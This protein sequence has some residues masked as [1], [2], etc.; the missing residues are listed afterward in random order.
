VHFARETAGAARTRLSLRP[1]ISWRADRFN[2]NSR[3]SCG[4]NAK[5]CLQLFLSIVITR[6]GG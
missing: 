1:L 5:L 2:N 3:E 6:E 4:E